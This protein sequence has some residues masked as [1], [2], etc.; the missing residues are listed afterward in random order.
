MC[1]T[2]VS[3]RSG[4]DAVQQVSQTG[5]FLHR[6]HPFRSAGAVKMEPPTGGTIMT[7]PSTGS[8]WSVEEPAATTRR[9]LGGLA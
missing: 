8:G 4:E 9:S 6:C 3:I 7:A 1:T 5:G 2:A